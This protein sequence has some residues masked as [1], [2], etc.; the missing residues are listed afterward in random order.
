[1]GSEMCIRDSGEYS[2]NGGA[3]MTTGGIVNN[4]NTIKLR[5]TSSND[6]S[7]TVRTTLTIGGVNGTF[8]STTLAKKVTSGGGGGSFGLWALLFSCM[9]LVVGVIKQ[10]RL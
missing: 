5:H 7:T 9:L 2:V 8:S 10:R 6:F 3:F 1:M 4:G